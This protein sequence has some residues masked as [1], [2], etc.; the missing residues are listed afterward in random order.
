M[1]EEGTEPN[2]AIRFDNM[3]SV[4]AS[5]KMNLRQAFDRN[6]R[7]Y[8]LRSRPISYEVGQQVLRRNFAQSNLSKHYNAKLDRV[9][10]PAIVHAKVGSC[11]YVLKNEQGKVLGTYHAKDMQSA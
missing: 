5:A 10:L 9:F 11:Y 6:E 4:R 3:Q 1:L 2:Q 8:N 7:H